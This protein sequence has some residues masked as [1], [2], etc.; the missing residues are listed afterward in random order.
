[1]SVLVTDASGNHA[2]AVIRSL[3]RK[4]IDVVAADSSRWAQGGFSRFCAA[5]TVYPSPAHGVQPFLRGLHRIIDEFSPEVLMPMTEQSILAMSQ[6]RPEIESRVRLAPLPSAEALRVAFDKK[7]TVGLAV[8]LGIAV[9]R[10]VVLRDPADFTV[11]HSRL[12]YPVVIKPRR[13]EA[14]TADG[15]VATGGPP[16]Y[17]FGPDELA[18]KYASVH[19]RAPSPLIQEFIPGEGYGVSALYN[20][21]RLKALFAHRRLRMIRPTG[22]GSSL[23]ESIAPPSDMVE[24]ARALLEALEWHGV[25]MVE[26]KRDARDGKPKLMEINGRFWN[27]LPLAVASGVDFPY[28]LYRLALE[29][30]CPE[31]F[32]Y[33][34]GVRGRWLAGDVRHLVEVLRGR[35]TGWTDRFPSRVGTVL[36]FLK[37]AG[38][39]VH[40]DDLWLTDPIPFFAGIAGAAAR[41]LNGRAPRHG[42]PALGAARDA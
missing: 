37:P 42:V 7:A 38:R 12:T 18:P 29:G 20:R 22:S 13:S 2:L 39:D 25:A 23:R 3:G 17:C 24:A 14:L 36:G 6:T 35:P 30:D 33:R 15:R 31:C 41:G 40:Y 8:S 9:P 21:G 10:T 16:A 11:L 28:L 5:R 4:G 19:E 1:M 32:E 27:S 26:F 34:T